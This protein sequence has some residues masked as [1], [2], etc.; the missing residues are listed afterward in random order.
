MNKL[1]EEIRKKQGVVVARSLV[2]QIL[3]NNK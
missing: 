2:R 3:D 1:Y